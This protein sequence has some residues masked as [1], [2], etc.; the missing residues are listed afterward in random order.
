ME[1]SQARIIPN[2]QK[3]VL[4]S[5]IGD[6]T[7]VNNRSQQSNGVHDDVVSALYDTKF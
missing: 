4:T 2:L 7:T 5:D 3:V 6:N 1:K